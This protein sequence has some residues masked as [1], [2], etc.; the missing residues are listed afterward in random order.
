MKTHHAVGLVAG[1]TMAGWLAT[2]GVPAAHADSPDPSSAATVKGPTSKAGPTAAASARNAHSTKHTG[3]TRRTHALPVS[4]SRA[5]NTTARQRFSLA[6]PAG[7]A[8]PTVAS[9]NPAPAAG[10]SPR[11]AAAP[12]SMRSVSAAPPA[13]TSSQLPVTPAQLP[14]LLAALEQVFR[15][16]KTSFFNGS[17]VATTREPLTTDNG[18]ITGLVVGIDPEGDPL[19]YRIAE[20]GT[21]GTVAIKS[22]GTYTYIPKASTLRNGGADSFLVQ[23]TDTGQ[24]LHLFNG[25]GST[26]IRVS[27]FTAP[28]GVP[29]GDLGATRG[30]NL[31]NLTSRSLTYTR[32]DGDAPDSGSPL[33]T[34]IA[35]GQYLHFEIGWNAYN[36]KN[37]A[38]WFTDLNPGP[39]GWWRDFMTV[40]ANSGY[41]YV[42]CQSQSN[43]ACGPT[44][45]QNARTINMMDAPGTKVHIGPDNPAAQESILDLLCDNSTPASCSFSTSTAQPQQ[46]LTRAPKIVS[47]ITKNATQDN[48][49]LSRSVTDTITR[50]DSI[51][52]SAKVSQKLFDLIN[53]EISATYGHTWTNSQAFSDTLKF[54]VR[55]GYMGYVVSE[56]PI[57]RDFGTFTVK[58]G[59]TEWTIDGVYFDSP[60]PAATKIFTATTVPIPS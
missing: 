26:Q 33:N 13:Q 36:D 2:F 17:P 23:V 21:G 7:A 27:V 35:P 43:V 49:D 18:T 47:D 28:Q 34:V 53:T 16:I 19:E 50:S 42:H 14:P 29:D 58:M 39:G 10:F 22:D 31:Y 38:V 55:P 41:G 15:Q 5:T 45:V 9:T 57:L 54:T 8:Q 32:L 4:A 44:D 48:L 24:H 6:N 37:T 46:K 20:P 3:E 52:I 60:D 59:N 56:E 11:V 30:F 51:S 12:I 40:T 25:N 1:A